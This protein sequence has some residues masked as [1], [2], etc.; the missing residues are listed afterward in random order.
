MKRH[1]CTIVLVLA[2][3]VGAGAWT[4]AAWA[5]DAPLT[6]E[7]KEELAAKRKEELHDKQIKGLGA[8]VL[9]AIFASVLFYALNIYN[10]AKKQKALLERQEAVPEDRIPLPY[11]HSPEPLPLPSEPPAGDW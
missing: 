1:R 9:A 6:A 3:L 4:P 5:E 8:C 11:S 2:S 7:E 10:K